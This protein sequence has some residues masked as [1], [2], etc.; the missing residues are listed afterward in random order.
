MFAKVEF[1]L[2]VEHRTTVFHACPAMLAANERNDSTIIR[3]FG[4]RLNG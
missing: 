2:M 4:A 3:R 1:A